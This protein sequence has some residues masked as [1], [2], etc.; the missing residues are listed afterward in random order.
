M[1]SAMI[2]DL[3]G[4]IVIAARDSIQLLTIFIRRSP[5]NTARNSPMRPDDKFAHLAVWGG[6]AG[7]LK[8]VLIV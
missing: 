1:P 7:L 8:K 5:R 6:K 3:D 2:C 4:V